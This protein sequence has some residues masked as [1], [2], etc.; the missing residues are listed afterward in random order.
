MV[1]IGGTASRRVRGGAVL[2]V[3][4]RV[5]ILE[6]MSDEI[7]IRAVRRDD[8]PELVGLCAAHAAYEQSDYDPTGKVD[9]LAQMLF[10]PTPRL[11]VRVAATGDELCGY[12]SWTCEASTWNATEYVLMDCL[13]L[14]PAARN[15]GVGRRLMQTMAEQALKAGRTL[16]QWQAPTENDGAIRFYERLG[17]TS[18]AKRRFFLRD[19]ALRQLAE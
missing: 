6:L 18:K 12:I 11:H 15:R 1:I 5:V 4:G 17:A 14:D 3:G 8:L 9:A 13:Y 19:E 7:T 16:I 2:P 10:K